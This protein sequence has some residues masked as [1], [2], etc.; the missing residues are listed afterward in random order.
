MRSASRPHLAVRLVYP[1]PMQASGY[2]YTPPPTPKRSG[3]PVWL[4]VLLSI[5]GVGIVL[6]A[7]MGVLAVA[8]MRGYISA[9][10]NAEAV[11]GVGQIARDAKEAYEEE[12]IPGGSAH[13]LCASASH[14]V[15]GSIVQVSAR[16][17]MSS[18]TD[19]SADPSDQGF[20]CLKYEMN[21]PQYYQYDYR[22]TGGATGAAVGDGFEAEAK[23]DLD[24]DGDTSSFTMT[25]SIT[26]A[27]T[28][29][30]APTVTRLH[31]SE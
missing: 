4:I 26:S 13:V 27:D 17:Y 23:G 25:G 28:L 12:A 16:K 19:W 22:R 11:N 18:A 9:S 10:K 15:P 30:L 5:L 8:G 3:F 7:V 6:V 24:G 14:P 29:T 31:E 20:T 21:S 1:P 2:P